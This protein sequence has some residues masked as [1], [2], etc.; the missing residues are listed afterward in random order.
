MPIS[1]MEGLASKDVKV[2]DVSELPLEDG[3]RGL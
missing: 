1:C 2:C 3:V